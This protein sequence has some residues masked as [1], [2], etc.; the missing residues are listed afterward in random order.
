MSSKWEYS[1]QKR[2][3]VMWETNLKCSQTHGEGDL[4]VILRPMDY[5][6]KH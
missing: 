1:K 4:K 2:S 3:D 5:F 6:Q